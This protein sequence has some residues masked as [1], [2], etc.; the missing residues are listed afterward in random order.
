MPSLPKQ[1]KT[2]LMN[3]IR[4]NPQ[5]ILIIIIIISVLIRV[6]SAIYV[7]NEV[8]ELPGTAD[9]IS[10]HNLA[11]RVLE[12][13]GFSFGEQWWPA[14]RANEPTAHWSYLYTS[15]LVVIYALTGS[16]PVVARILQAIIVGILMPWMMYRLSKRLFNGRSDSEQIGLAA[17]AIM[18]V[19]VYFFYYAV[20]LMTES[21]YILAILW[22]FDLAFQIVDSEES[23]W[24]L[25]VLLGVALA[26]AVLLR[27]LFLLFIPFLLLWLWWVKRP[28]LVKLA[29]PLVITI[30]MMLPWTIRNYIAFDAV[31]PLNT[32]SGYAFFW[33]NH[34]IYGTKFVPILTA[35]MG[36]YYDLIPKELLPLNEAEIDSALLKLGIQFITDAPGRYL[37]LS[38]SRIPSYFIFWPSSDSG[39]ISNLSRV[40][41]FGLFLPFMLYGLL[42]TLREGLT[43][44][45]TPFFLL[46]LFMLVY[47]GIHILI[48]TLIRYRLPLDAILIMFAGYALVDLVT[49]FSARRSAAML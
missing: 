11:L 40:A 34:P 44:L 47:T 23:G 18:A 12:G 36:T 17:A 37:L 22:C 45:K 41:S 15:F 3:N 38:L 33:G 6:I 10:Y 30:L 27:Q 39:M 20:A 13:Y 32:N 26:T 48:W 28:Q 21:F 16:N 43:S 9:Q 19:Y 1:K 29:L 46:Y 14:T 4:T 2:P 7:G 35:D 8:V 25:W 5:K 49:W 42:R 31:V 24:R